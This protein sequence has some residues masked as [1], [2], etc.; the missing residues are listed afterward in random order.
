MLLLNSGPARAQIAPDSARLVGKL[1]LVKL[2]SSTYEAEVE[3]RHGQRFSFSL[4][5]RLVSGK[6]NDYSANST[7]TITTSNDQIRGY[8]LGFGSRFYIPNTGTEG[9]RLAGLYIGL[10]A[11]YQH[12]RLSYQKEVW[13]EDPAPDGLLYYTFRNRKFTETINRYGGAATLGYQCQIFLPRL[14]LDASA[15]LN[16]LYSRSSA[17]QASR[18]R[19]F[20]ADYAYSGA[21]WTMGLSVGY[22]L[23]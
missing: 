22:V 3:Y 7:I 11:E 4:L 8:G 19:S 20:Q 14:R 23:K 10:K 21:L 13:G 18:Y 2:F 1:A 15:S 17:G 16:N 6:P 12:L 9:T 5:P